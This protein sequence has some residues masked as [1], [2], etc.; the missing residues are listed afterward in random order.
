MASLAIM[1]LVTAI[2][3]TLENHKISQKRQNFKLK[4][5]KYIKTYAGAQVIKKLMAQ[6]LSLA[7]ARHKVI[8]QMR[9]NNVK[10]DKKLYPWRYRTPEE[11][12]MRMMGDKKF[13]TRYINKI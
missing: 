8:S 4:I 7:E 11:S 5:R 6:G 1:G 13:R 10:E 9:L 3:A 12:F 2:G